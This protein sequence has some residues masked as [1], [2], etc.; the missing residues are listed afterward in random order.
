MQEGSSCSSTPPVEVA[1]SSVYI[2]ITLL[3]GVWEPSAW[4]GRGLWQWEP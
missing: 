4:S 3:Y 2:D 1:W